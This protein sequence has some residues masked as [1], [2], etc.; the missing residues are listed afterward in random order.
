MVSKK[1]NHSCEY[2]MENLSLLITVCHHSASLV[3]PIG[4]PRAGL[5][6]PT[7]I[8]MMD[9]YI[10]TKVTIRETGHICWWPWFLTVQIC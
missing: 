8:L 7:L 4:D 9:S 3:M 2:G 5:F 1:K 10:L 6:Y